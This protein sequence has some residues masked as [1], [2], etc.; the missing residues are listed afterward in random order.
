MGDSVIYWSKKV[1]QLLWA[2][3]RYCHG[4]FFFLRQL[5]KNKQQELVIKRFNICVSNADAFDANNM[6]RMRKDGFML[7]ITYQ[8]MCNK[9]L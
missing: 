6:P 8:F 9:S 3:T 4:F 5:A 2:L 7:N 1:F